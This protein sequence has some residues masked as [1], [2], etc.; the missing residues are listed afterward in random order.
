MGKG[1]NVERNNIRVGH[2]Y[3]ARCLPPVDLAMCPELRF[4]LQSVRFSGCFYVFDYGNAIVLA[5]GLW[6]LYYITYKPYGWSHVPCVL[7]AL[8]RFSYV[9]SD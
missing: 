9:P 3:T 6:T 7:F 1:Y 5:I 2:I 4:A 8:Q